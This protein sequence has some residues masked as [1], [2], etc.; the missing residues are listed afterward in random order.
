MVT[1]RKAQRSNTDGQCVELAATPG[2]V[3]VRDSKAP[4]RGHLT[5]TRGQWQALTEQI[6]AGRV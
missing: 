1:W 5:L 4:G 6:R 3:L 2:A